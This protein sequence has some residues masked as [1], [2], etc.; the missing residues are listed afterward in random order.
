MYNVG[1]LLLLA[2]LAGV[3]V[4][5][6]PFIR[7]LAFGV[8][9]GAVLFPAKKKLAECINKWIDKI[10]RND[11]PVL[12]GIVKIPFNA[13]EWLGELI[14]LFILTHIKIIM[15]GSLSL[16]TL[17]IL[18]YFLP[19]HFFHHVI[20]LIQWQHALFEKVIGSFN[21]TIVIGIIIAY[22]LTVYLM[23]NSSNSSI[24]T[25]SGQLIWLLI[26]AYGCSYFGPFQIPIFMAIVVY[27]FMGLIYHDSSC[28]QYFVKIKRVFKK[29]DSPQEQQ[30]QEEETFEE[31]HLPSSTPLAS[32]KE[33]L[34]KTKT[35][36]SEIKSKMQLNVSQHHDS[37]STKS[38]SDVQLESNWYFKIL[39][40]ALAATILWKQIWI[41]TFCFIPVVFYSIKALCKTLGIN[42]Y[43]E[44]QLQSPIAIF[45]DG[46]KC[47]N[48]R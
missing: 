42:N 10:E 22:M 40:Y 47:A 43:I 27:G 35:H 31:S 18:L 20:E 48:T 7:P 4:I 39:F 28:D 13:L 44:A 37:K 23:W 38:K 30:Q 6:L 8:I 41:L 5:L 3:I 9:F 33:I 25:V 2:A 24:F 14:I 1:L 32:S 11:T 29:E 15:Y 26:I 12:V 21:T 45:K 19:K 16:I 36:L 46:S 17:R 34:L